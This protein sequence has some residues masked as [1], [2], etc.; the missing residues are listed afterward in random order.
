F[1]MTDGRIYHQG[2]TLAFPDGQIQTFGSVGLDDSV[3]IMVEFSVPLAWLP[4]SAVTDAIRKQKL[5][6]PMGGTL[7]SP[8]IDFAE[9]ARVKNQVLGNL[10]RSALQG[11]GVLK[12]GA[13]QGVGELGNQL[14]KLIKPGH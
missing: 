10:A 2:L 13:V 4:K 11:S 7:D 12:N 5:Q 14:N 6:V 8:R 3:K 1:R 9:L